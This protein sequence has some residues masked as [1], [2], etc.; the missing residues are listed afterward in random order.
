MDQNGQW[1]N[2]LG[3]LILGKLYSLTV[4]NVKPYDNFIKFGK[5]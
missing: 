5:H 3:K 2:G 4:P 1:T